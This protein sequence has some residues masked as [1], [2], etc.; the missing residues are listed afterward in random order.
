VQ[1][2]NAVVQDAPSRSAVDQ[3][4]DQVIVREHE[5]IA[6]TNRYH[7][8]IETYVQDVKQQGEEYPLSRDWYYLGQAEFGAPLKVGSMIDYFARDRRAALSMSAPPPKRN[9]RLYGREDFRF[10]CNVTCAHTRSLFLS[11][12][13]HFPLTGLVISAPEIG[14]SKDE[15][16]C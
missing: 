6:A 4:I 11:D 1:S 7:P 16:Y 3:A 10:Y 15:R 5:E 14:K 2:S 8:I 9:K 13:E 12:L